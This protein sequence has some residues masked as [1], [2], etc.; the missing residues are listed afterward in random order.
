MRILH[1]VEHDHKRILPTF[2]ADHVIEVAIL[3]GRGDSYDALMRSPARHLVELGAREK[4]HWH[5]QTPA[6]FDHALEADIVSLL[7][8]A[9][10]LEGASPGLERFGDRVDAI[11]IVHKNS[12]QLPVVSRQSQNSRMFPVY[13]KLNGVAG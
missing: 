8:H 13:R 7:R 1:A 6:V 3:F 11:D 2:G 4:F 10:P 5:A 9:D 12:C